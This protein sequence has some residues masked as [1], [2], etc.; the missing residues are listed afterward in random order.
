METAG[1]PDQELATFDVIVSKIEV[2]LGR[3]KRARAASNRKRPVQPP[4]SHAPAVARTQIGISDLVTSD[5]ISD[6]LTSIINEASQLLKVHNA[7]STRMPQDDHGNPEATSTNHVSLSS[8]V[9]DPHIMAI[10]EPESQTTATATAP[11]LSEQASRDR[12]PAE[13]LVT[14][15]LTGPHHPSA[16]IKHELDGRVLVL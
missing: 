7:A 11:T 9:P 12:H 16:R 4:G 15:A 8:P 6:T 3:L 14:E 10:T 1:H 2:L 13:A 5:P